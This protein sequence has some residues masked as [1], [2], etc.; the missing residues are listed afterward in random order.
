MDSIPHVARDTQ[1]SDAYLY[2]SP[3]PSAARIT[4]SNAPIQVASTKR[5]YAGRADYAAAHYI[6][7]ADLDRWQWQHV[8]EVVLEH[9]TIDRPA[10]KFETLNGPRWRFSD[11]KGGY[12]HNK[13]YERCWYGLDS[14]VI[15]SVDDESPLI[16]CNGEISTVTAQTYLLLAVCVTSGEKPTIPD[17]LLE[18]LKAAFPPGT[19]IL[20]VDD[21]DD[22]GRKAAAGKAAQLIEAGFKARAIDLGLSD[23]GDLADACGLYGSKTLEYLLQCAEIAPA[24]RPA[25]KPY[26]MPDAPTRKPA[27]SAK[28]AAH[29]AQ[30]DERRRKWFDKTWNGIVSSLEATIHGRNDAL[31]THARRLFDLVYTFSQFGYKSESEAYEA[32]Y[33][34]SER[35]GY[36]AKDGDV[37]VRS[38]IKSA[39]GKPRQILNTPDFYANFNPHD[40]KGSKR[41]F[42]APAEK[43]ETRELTYIDLDENGEPIEAALAVENA[44]IVVDTLP[45]DMIERGREIWGLA[46]MGKIAYLL[47]A[48]AH[49]LLPEFFTLKDYKAIS[50]TPGDKNVFT[51]MLEIGI[52]IDVSSDLITQIPHISK[53]TWGK[54]VIK[55]PGR[56]EKVY[57]LATLAELRELMPHTMARSLML[58]SVESEQLPII[59]ESVKPL[60]RY[61]LEKFLKFKGPLKK[62]NIGLVRYYLKKADKH[63]DAEVLEAIRVLRITDASLIKTMNLQIAQCVADAYASHVD[64]ATAVLIEL[65]NKLLMR[66]YQA[67]KKALSNPVIVPLPEGVPSTAQAW[68]NLHYNA[69]IKPH[70]GGY[71]WPHELGELMGIEDKDTIKRTAAR[72]G[73]T[74]GETRFD[75][76]EFTVETDTDHR[77]SWEEIVI[78]GKNAIKHEDKALDGRVRV[79]GPVQMHSVIRSYDDEGRLVAQGYVSEADE[80]DNWRIGGT[81]FTIECEFRPLI[82]VSDVAPLAATIEADEPEESAGITP[83]ETPIDESLDDEAIHQIAAFIAFVKELHRAGRRRRRESQR[84]ESHRITPARLRDDNWMLRRVLAWYCFNAEKGVFYNPLTGEIHETREDAVNDMIDMI[85]PSELQAVS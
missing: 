63:R 57:R 60:V 78:A 5:A 19:S 46:I 4:L 55:S 61:V 20:I 51:E 42:S 77:P 84:N 66:Q 26:V 70:N 16:I 64:E 50:D 72:A 37:A 80:P 8:K 79:W 23:G 35:N 22:T 71:L 74:I 33:Q 28:N 68:A 29:E 49:G 7:D 76:R 27:M 41:K 30:A 1:H 6:T 81:H 85:Q 13:G 83:D 12:I 40:P 56:K 24:T 69:L 45:K 75:I 52:L 73:I 11:A 59:D 14:D 58:E 10:F 47:Y 53:N 54:Q 48:I 43:G 67:Y 2:A 32:M 39:L 25:F 18:E 62:V 3:Q 34:A 17:N 38:A 9:R 82:T 31:Y 36:R 65:K 21:C 15:A 44:G